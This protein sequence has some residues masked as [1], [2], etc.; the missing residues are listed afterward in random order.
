MKQK[1]L[2][3]LTTGSIL[4]AIAV[5]LG[6]IIKYTPGIN[7][8]MPNG[9]AVFGIYIVP[10]ILSGMILGYKYGILT[11]LIYGVVSWLLDGYVIHWGSIFFDYLIPFSLMGFAGSLFYGKGLSNWKNIVFAFLIAAVF[12]WIMHGFSGV[13][14]FQQYAGD[15]NPWFYSFIIYNAPYVFAG[16]TISLVITLIIRKPLV[17]LTKELQLN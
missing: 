2:K 3:K 10:V 12:R 8:E 7:L 6:V 17:D 9:G 14:F 13:L 11:G 4:A 1:E 16:A 5:V 15:Y